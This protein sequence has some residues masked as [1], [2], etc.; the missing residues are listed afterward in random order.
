MSTWVKK[1]LFYFTKN[2]ADPANS[3]A[4]TWIHLNLLEFTWI[5][6]VFSVFVNALQ[7]DGRKDGSLIQSCFA[8]LLAGSALFFFFLL[9][10]LDRLLTSQNL[11]PT[12]VF[13]WWFGRLRAKSQ[14]ISSGENNLEVPWWQSGPKVEPRCCVR[15][16]KEIV[17]S[18]KQ[19]KR[20]YYGIFSRQK[21]NRRYCGESIGHEENWRWV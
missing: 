13:G 7:K 6:L 15:G 21:A 1:N 11:K 17:L 19:A 12:N 14:L 10:F 20:Q 4:N 18:V 16:Q 8:Q 5:L 9:M 2:K 3:C